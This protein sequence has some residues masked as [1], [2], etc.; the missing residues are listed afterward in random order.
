MN[1]VKESVAGLTKAKERRHVVAGIGEVLWDLLP[2]GPPEIGGA[3]ANFVYHM[4]ILGAESHLFSA[5]G[6][7]TLGHDLV[8]L[9]ESK[10]L[11][12]GHIVFASAPTGTVSVAIDPKGKP[13]YHI[14]DNVAWDMIPC[15]EQAEFQAGMLDAVCFGTLAQ[16]S[17]RSRASI[18]RIL[19][20]TKPDCIK[21]L[22]INLRE[23]YFHR[24]L[25]ES[26]L[27]L[28]TILK[29]SDEELPVVCRLLGSPVDETAAL[30]F[31]IRNFNLRAV[32]L[33]KGAMGCRIVMRG[34]DISVPGIRI[35][36]IIDTVGAGDSFTAMLTMGLLGNW[37]TRLIA[38]RANR[39]AAFVCSRHGGMP[40]VPKSSLA[41]IMHEFDSAL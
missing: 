15:G 33:T 22:D 18:R 27:E 13:R 9:L 19:G 5:V 31:L 37:P 32:A 29:L 17:E 41:S 4:A 40:A 12:A 34:E 20:L 14:T 1:Y 30:D 23:G 26:S 35:D 38:E 25:L 8:L 39:L 28:S 3:P 6:N 24:E 10:G 36:K 21:V 7:D 2:F 11:N 16:R